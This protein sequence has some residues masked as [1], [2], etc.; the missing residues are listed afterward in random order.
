MDS[1]SNI[2]TATTVI[3]EIFKEKNFPYLTFYLEYLSSEATHRQ[4][5][6]EMLEVLKAIE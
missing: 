1:D 3:E 5:L 6:S 4:A 2:F